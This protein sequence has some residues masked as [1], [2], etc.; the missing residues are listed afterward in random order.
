M[1]DYIKLFNTEQEQTAFIN[2]NN[3]TQPHISCVVNG[4]NLT[5]NQHSPEEWEA[6]KTPF[7]VKVFSSGS[8]S[9]NLYSGDE[10]S[11]SKNGGDWQT[12][13]NNTVL[14]VQL[15]DE[16]QFKGNGVFRRIYDEDR[17]IYSYYGNLVCDA[18][19]SVKGN[20][21]S[22]LSDSYSTN[23]VAPDHCFYCLFSGCTTLVNAEELLLPATTVGY[24]SYGY[25]FKECTGLLKSVKSLPATTLGQS[26]YSSMFYDCENLVETVRILPATTLYA[27]CYHQMFYNCKKLTTA[28]QLPA[29]T[30]ANY[31]YQRMFFNCYLLQEAPA[32]PADVLAT[33][34]YSNMFAQC[35][36]L[37]ATPNL[38]ARTLSVS[39][40]DSMFAGCIS[41]TTVSELPATAL[42]N[43][44]YKSMFFNC[45]SLINAQSELPAQT[46]I[47]EC[48]SS[49]FYGC[50]KLVK[51]PDLPALTLVTNCYKQMF[52]GCTSLTYIK[53]LFTT[54]PGQSYTDTWVQQVSG[55]GTFVKNANASWTTVNNYGVP[56]GWTIE[57]VYV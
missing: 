48:Y 30:L 4:S 57:T 23:K 43:S 53:A 28:P 22:L 25:M 6:L 24:F 5:Y 19:F 15:D 32:L 54:T 11:Y 46:L 45:T 20:I 41:L 2:S 33:S 26:C 34:C 51:A 55:S 8:L 56:Q 27:N 9:W 14:S 40:Y 13:N 10:L 35:K 47:S 17:D 37:T 36:A 7:T 52:K 31:C 44:C 16:I 38:G 12:M 18:V 50:S 1:S 49:M 39:C 21:M 3:Y 42:A 29:T